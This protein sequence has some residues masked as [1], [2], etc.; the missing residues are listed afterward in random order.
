MAFQKSLLQ[1]LIFYPDKISSFVRAIS[2]RPLVL[3]ACLTCTRSSHPT[4]L[5]LPVVVPYSPPLSLRAVA[6][7]P[8]SS[9]GRGDWPTLLRYA[10]VTPII[11][12]IFLKVIPVPDEICPARVLLL[13]V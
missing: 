2:E 11:R 12:S 6:S 10:F 13:V 8:S 9:V 1:S 7:L 4:L 3:T 5:G